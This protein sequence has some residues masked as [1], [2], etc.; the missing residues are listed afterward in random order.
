MLA[1]HLNLF[2]HEWDKIG[3]LAVGFLSLGFP[4]SGEGHILTI[5][6][7]DKGLRVV[8][9]GRQGACVCWLL[10]TT[11]LGVAGY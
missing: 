6:L 1:G 7:N 11:G 10:S 5:Y 4:G 3:G 9:K 8:V 2:A